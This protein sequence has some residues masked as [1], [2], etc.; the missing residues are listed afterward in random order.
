MIKIL[1]ICHGN[2]CR[3]PM[4]EFIM[5]DIVKKN[6]TDHLFKVS[7]CA[8]SREEI[9]NDMYP[10]AKR[11][12]DEKGISYSKRR[13]RQITEADFAENDY[14]ICMDGNNIRNL[15]RIFSSDKAGR[16]KMLMSYCGEERDVKDPWYTGDFEEAYEDI[17]N[18]CE[19]LYEFIM[20]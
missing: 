7:S 16:V 12:L 10:P 18:G 9:G 8:T 19:A 15:N 5:K 13:A 2:I 20:K 1:F 14:L 17:L 3:S 6:G 11:K 4:A